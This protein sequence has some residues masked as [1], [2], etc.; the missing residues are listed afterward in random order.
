M[1]T[2][3]DGEEGLVLPL[4]TGAERIQA[5]ALHVHSLR[6]GEKQSEKK[7]REEG[8]LGN[9]EKTVPCPIFPGF[10]PSS[11]HLSFVIFYVS[12]V[13]PFELSHQEVQ[14]LVAEAFGVS[15]G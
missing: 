5:I 13:L 6:K 12:A 15:L 3:V 2:L 4:A 8:K 9:R 7:R 1:V 14:A 10:N 11:V